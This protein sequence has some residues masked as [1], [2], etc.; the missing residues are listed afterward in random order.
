[1]VGVPGDCRKLPAQLCCR[2]V[3]LLFGIRAPDQQPTLVRR[4]HKTFHRL[5]GVATTV[6]H[7][8]ERGSRRTRQER[9]AG[10]LVRAVIELR[11]GAGQ[12]HGNH[13]GQR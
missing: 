12:Q 11:V 13:I 9:I 4:P 7:R 1:M 3:G 10:R 2:Q 8:R 5:L 6:G